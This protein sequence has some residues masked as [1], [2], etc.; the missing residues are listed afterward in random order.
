MTGEQ[1]WIKMLASFSWWRVWSRLA[2]FSSIYFMMIW[3]WVCRSTSE[4]LFIVP[5]LFI[6]HSGGRMSSALPC[7]HSRDTMQMSSAD[8]NKWWLRSSCLK[9]SK[10][11]IIAGIQ[12]WEVTQKGTGF[13]TDTAGTINTIRKTLLC[14]RQAGFFISSC[15][16][17]SLVGICFRRQGGENK[18]T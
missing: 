1:V 16:S 9:G 6:K 18:V 17:I 5:F 3:S 8:G 13:S 10:S 14:Q 15:T 2:I 7:G 4:K 12:R 11:E